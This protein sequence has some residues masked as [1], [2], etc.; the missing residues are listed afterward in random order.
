MFLA[1]NFALSDAE[2]NTSRTLNRGGK[3]D[4]PLL[5]TLLAIHQ[6]SREPSFREKIDSFVLLAHASFKNPIVMITSFSEIY[7]KFRRFIPMKY[8]SNDHKHHCNQH[9]N[10]HKLFNEMTHTLLNLMKSQW[11]LKQ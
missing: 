8:L 2:G 6:K 9:K 5:R 4:L 3:A 7:F 1:N 11:K 10:S